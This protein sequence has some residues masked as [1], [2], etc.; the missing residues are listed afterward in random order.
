MHQPRSYD[1]YEVE[2][3]HNNKEYDQKKGQG[4]DGSD[5][6]SSLGWLRYFWG[7]LL[8]SA[9][10]LRWESSTINLRPLE[11]SPN[12]LGE[13]IGKSRSLAGPSVPETQ[14]R[15]VS[16]YSVQVPYG[17]VPLHIFMA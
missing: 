12:P 17:V 7:L 9:R 8:A 15:I 5:G 14:S 2:F 3:T 10:S 1:G 6:G 16:S 4:K 11:Y 13:S